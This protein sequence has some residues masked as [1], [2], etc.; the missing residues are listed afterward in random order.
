MKDSG[1]EHKP[2]CNPS[3][4]LAHAGSDATRK[5]FLYIFKAG[6]R[7]AAFGGRPRSAEPGSI[8]DRGWQMI[9]QEFPLS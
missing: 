6:L 3:P 7:A 9:Q 2:G 5:N 4:S 1:N 8:G